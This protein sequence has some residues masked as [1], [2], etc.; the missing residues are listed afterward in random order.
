MNFVCKY[1][2]CSPGKWP[3]NWDPPEEFAAMA[4]GNCTV[5][6]PFEY[7]N[8]FKKNYDMFDAGQIETVEKC[9]EPCVTTTF[10]SQYSWTP[11]RLKSASKDVVPSVLHVYFDDFHVTIVREIDTITLASVL[12]NVGGAMGVFLGA[13]LISVVEIFIFGFDVLK[14]LFSARGDSKITSS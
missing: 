2:L 8:C 4:T 7:Y 11:F 14:D 10:R 3:A 13:S 9:K 1:C 6:S 5:C 12:A